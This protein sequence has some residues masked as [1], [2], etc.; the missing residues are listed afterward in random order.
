VTPRLLVVGTGLIGTSIG[1]AVHGEYDVQ[2]TDAE[3][4]RVREAAGRGAGRPW[5]GASVD[6]AVVAVPPG[7]TAATLMEHAGV[8]RYL[9]HVASC[10]SAVAADLETAD[11][12]RICGG[13]PL[14]GREVSG[15]AG[16][17]AELFYGRPWA[18]CRLPGTSD[19]A[20]DAVHALAVACGAQPLHL[21]PGD[22]DRAVALSS[23]L[24]Q[25]A[26]SALAAQLLASEAAS[27][28]ISGPGLQ[29]TTRVAASSP[30]L[31]TEILAGNAA[32]VAPLVADLAGDL[33][34]L[35]DALAVLAH[36]PADAAARTSVE[37][38]LRRGNDGRARVPVK[39]GVLDRDVAVVRVRIPDR[40]GS[41]A[42]LL[43]AAGGAGVNVED[44]RVEHLPGRRTGVAELLV[45]TGQTAA[46]SAALGGAGF[47][48]LG[49]ADPR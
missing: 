26:A 45:Q 11:T 22:H 10:Q 35:A 44:L 7:R 15:P 16:A 17:S 36:D 30:E 42:E 31:W 20:R 33:G 5:D 1:L 34:R 18:V 24:P 29:D 2:L 4:S 3:T 28:G 23:H 13:H 49:G 14:A 39:R 40:P 19:E 43:A 38:L 32:H 37:A 47:E 6:L 25:L 27:V 41:L 8:A 9:T 48:V 21:S 46:L 12:T